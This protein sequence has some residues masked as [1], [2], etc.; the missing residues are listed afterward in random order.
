MTTTLDELESTV[1]KLNDEVYAQTEPSPA[2]ITLRP[3]RWM[4][5][6]ESQAVTFLSLP[7]WDSEEDERGELSPGRLES[8]EKFVRRE[9][10]G[11]IDTIKLIS[12]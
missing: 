4:S 10:K 7:V 5:C 9:T 2:G 1:G 8:I 11:I 12:L 3:F 6:G